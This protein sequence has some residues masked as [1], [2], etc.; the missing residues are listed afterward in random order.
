MRSSVWSPHLLKRINAIEKEQKQFTKRIYSLSHLSYSERLAA[1]N[2]EPLELRRLK[3][4]QV[5]GSPAG[6]SRVN[7]DGPSSAKLVKLNRL[8]KSQ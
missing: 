4:D 2:L 8:P 5:T 6:L 3:N 1:I 7:G